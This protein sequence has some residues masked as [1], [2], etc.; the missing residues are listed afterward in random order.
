PRFDPAVDKASGYRTRC[1]LTLPLVDHKDILVGVMQGLN[2]SGSVFDDD[3][4]IL[5][6]ALAAQCAVALQRV[7]MTEALI[8]GEK[9]RQELE[10]A[11][12]V[13]MSTLPASMPALPG[14]DVYGTFKPAELTGGDTFD[15]A[16]LDQ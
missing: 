6:T 10:V 16:A 5:A 1:M 3:D 15:L 8:E 13:Q 11:R 12:V 7:R 14:Y 9:M 4:E 2:K